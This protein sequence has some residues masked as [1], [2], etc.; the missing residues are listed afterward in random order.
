[1]AD[2]PRR[3]VELVAR[4]SYGRLVAYLSARTR[5]VAAAEDAL[6]DAFL[7]ALRT[8]PRDGVPGKPEAWLFTTARRRLVDRA[9]HERVQCGGRADHPA[10]GGRPLARGGGDR[11]PRLSRRPAEAPLR[12]R[13]PRGRS[14]HAHAAHAAG[15]PRSRRGD[16]CERLPHLA[17]RHGAAVEPR[18]SQDPRRRHRVRSPGSPRAAGAARRGARRHLRRV[19]DRLGRCGGIRSA[20]GRSGAG[21]GVARAHAA[22]VAARRAGSERFAGVDAV[23]RGAAAGQACRQRRLRADVGAGCS[24]LVGAAARGSRTRAHGR[25]RR[26][27]VPGDSSSKP[28]CNRRTSKARCE[29][30][31]TGARSQCSTRG[32]CSPRRPPARLSAARRPLPK[33][34]VRRRDSTPSIAIDPSSIKSYQPYWAVRA[35]LLRRA[36]R[37]DEALGA[38]D[39]AIGLT[40]DAATRQFLL[41]RRAEAESTT[42]VTP[43][44]ALVGR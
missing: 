43:H 5:D 14:R 18:Q 31:R 7:A 35:H 40:E 11:R 29:G 21:G 39:R 8:W 16:D 3:V 28:R 17:G 23:L 9:R 13:A 19:R 38:Y 30:R 37:V 1:M 34:R 42:V 27:S 26:S 32:C 6:A 36:G 24:S 22:A 2:D 33:R 44:R 10:A 41:R 12:L 20:A 15:R 25:V 4:E